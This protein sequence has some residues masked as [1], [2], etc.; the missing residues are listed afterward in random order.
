MSR[1]RVAELGRRIKTPFPFAGRGQISLRVRRGASARHMTTIPPAQPSPAP[2]PGNHGDTP[3]SAAVAE[4]APPRPAAAPPMDRNRELMD[5]AKAYAY[6]EVGETSL[7]AHVF[8]PD[9]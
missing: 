7:A 4:T 5:R 3:E 6:K 8:Y 9:E 2:D 1:K